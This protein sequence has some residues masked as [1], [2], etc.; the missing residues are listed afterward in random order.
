MHLRNVIHIDPWYNIHPTGSS[1]MNISEKCKRPCTCPPVTP[2][3]RGLWNLRFNVASC[4]SIVRDYWF[5]LDFYPSG[6]ASHAWR[7]QVLPILLL[8]QQRVHCFGAT[9]LPVKGLLK[10]RPWPW[11]LEAETD[12]ERPEL[13]I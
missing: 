4:A 3:Q 12:F 10:E 6:R 11:G 13:W 7:I 2:K 8:Q 5:L 9:C 1:G